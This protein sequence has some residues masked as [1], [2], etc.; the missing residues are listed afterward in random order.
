MAALKLAWDNFVN[1]S[2]NP[3]EMDLQSAFCKLQTQEWQFDTFNI[4]IEGAKSKTLSKNKRVILFLFQI[5]F[6]WKHHFLFHVH[7]E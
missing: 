2:F 3:M 5:E 6:W 4:E 7:K 1:F